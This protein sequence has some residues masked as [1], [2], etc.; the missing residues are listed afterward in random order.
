MELERK[1]NWVCIEEDDSV[2]IQYSMSKGIR[3]D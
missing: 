1:A 3:I 2:G